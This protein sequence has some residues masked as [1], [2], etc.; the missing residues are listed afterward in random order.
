[1]QRRSHYLSNVEKV[2]HQTKT[3][4]KNNYERANAARKEW[5]ARN[6][7]KVKAQRKAKGDRDSS[8]LSDVYVAWNLLGI[9]LSEA[10]SALIEAKRLHL[11]IKR[12]I[13]NGNQ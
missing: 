5:R 1:V 6:P 4:T 10:P 9:P 12:L 3:W 2:S 8:S 7:E 13:K 11:Q